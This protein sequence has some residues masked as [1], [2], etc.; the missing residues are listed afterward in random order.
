MSE[1]IARL[2]ELLE[3]ATVART[4]DVSWLS[5][6]ALAAGA[7]RILGAPL[8]AG[9]MTDAGDQL[10]L[11]HDDG[12]YYRSNYERGLL[13]YALV[14]LL[15]ADSVVEVGTGR[16]FGS[17]AAM[18]AAAHVDTIDVVSPAVPV[19]AWRMVDD[20]GRT[21]RASPG[22]LLMAAARRHS[23]SGQVRHHVGTSLAH[24]PALMRIPPDLVFL[25]GAHEYAAVA[26][27]LQIVGPSGAVVLLDDY[28]LGLFGI[29]RAV[30]ELIRGPIRVVVTDRTAVPD[31]DGSRRPADR[32]DHG[33]VIVLPGELRAPSAMHRATRWILQILAPSPGATRFA[34]RAGRRL[35]GS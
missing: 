19:T 15:G 27:E 32:A 20:V 28:H 12:R 6:P 5:F 4:G 31:L 3:A 24:L 2:R 17:F 10:A 30:H 7:E 22:A 35:L 34:L 9:V 18:L 25:D 26:A 33:M 16:G 8:P 14:R 1:R 13:V 21:E 11:R 29:R 23:A